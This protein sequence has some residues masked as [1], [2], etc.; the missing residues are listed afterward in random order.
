ML[1][2][3]RRL[4]F[5]QNLFPSK[6]DESRA[7]L[8]TGSQ[9][10]DVSNVGVAGETNTIR[11]GR[12]GTHKHTVNAGISGGTVAGL[13]VWWQIIDPLDHSRDSRTYLAHLAELEA[14]ARAAKHGAWPV[15]PTCA[16]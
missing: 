16:P 2:S 9:N 15:E 11:I 8:T 13:L 3:A 4:S 1:T 14:P 5:P 6:R 10:I 12:V 7:A